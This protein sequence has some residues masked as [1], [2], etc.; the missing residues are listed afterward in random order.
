MIIIYKTVLTPILNKVLRFQLWISIVTP[1][2]ISS[3][4]PWFPETKFIFLRQYTKS[5]LI[6]A[7]GKTFPKYEIQFGNCFPW[8]NIKKGRNL[9]NIV[10][11]DITAI[12]NIIDS[13][14]LPQN[15][16]FYHLNLRVFCIRSKE[17]PNAI[18]K[19]M[20]PAITGI[21]CGNTCFIICFIK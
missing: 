16:S 4:I 10:T 9:S 21:V 8:S 2:H 13:S 1:T 20:Y 3:G 18:P 17:Q 14:A 6:I 19:D 7:G 15:N 5:I 12:T 11:I